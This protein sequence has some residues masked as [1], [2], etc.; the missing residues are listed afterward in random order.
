LEDIAV[1]LPNIGS[2][3]PD[4]EL[5]ESYFFPD[6]GS[7]LLSEAIIGGSIE[8]FIISYLPPTNM[9]GWDYIGKGGSGDLVPSGLDEGLDSRPSNRHRKR[10]KCIGV[11]SDSSNL[12]LGDD[13]SMDELL[14]LVDKSMVGKVY[15]RHFS[16]KTLKLWAYA[17]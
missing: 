14:E 17:T 6:V 9:N 11:V 10:N 7:G 4:P 5:Q 15:V 13:L 2:H 12:T 8:G 1:E 3:R 16:E